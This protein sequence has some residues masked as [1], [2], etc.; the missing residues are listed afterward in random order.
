MRLIGLCGKSGSG[1]SVFAGICGEKGIVV[2]DCDKVYAELVSSPGECLE[3]IKKEFGEGSV[4]DGALNREYVAGIVFSDKKKL[5]SLNAITHKHILARLCELVSGLPEESKV[6]FDAPTL[7]ESGLYMQCELIVSVIA[8]EKECLKR[9]TERDRISVDKAK[10]RL[11]SQKSD[12][13]LIANSDVVI[14]NDAD[15]GSFV[16]ACE[17]TAADICG[18]I[19]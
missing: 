6:L 19:L 13:F 4:K 8:P 16:S 9:I 14:Y 12:E 1:K 18:G 2:I 3:E 7:F 5:E 17:Q 15:F 11:A 10:A